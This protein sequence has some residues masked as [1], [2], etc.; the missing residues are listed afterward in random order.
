MYSWLLFAN[1]VLLKKLMMMMMM[2]TYLEVK[3]GHQ[4]NKCCH[5]QCTTQV[6]G[7]TIFLK[8]ARFYACC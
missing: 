2:M 6:V 4:A 1:C 5:K 7:I 8:L 3:L